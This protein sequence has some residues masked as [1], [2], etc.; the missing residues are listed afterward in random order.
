MI[1]K[2]HIKLSNATYMIYNDELLWSKACHN[3]Y[4]NPIEYKYVS[5]HV[6]SPGNNHQ[7]SPGKNG[8]FV[9][10]KAL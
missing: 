3:I 7:N 4:K 5:D 6:K 1:K 8:N 9:I 10:K 2:G